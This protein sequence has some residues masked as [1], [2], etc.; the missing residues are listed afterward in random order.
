[1]LMPPGHVR[2]PA[3]LRGKT[4]T[5]ERDLGAFPN[6]EALAYAQPAPSL[7]LHRVR[8]AMGEIWGGEAENP[9]DTLDAEIYEHWLEAVD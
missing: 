4:G 1:M 2:T 9:T 8:F 7:A 6:P 5:I 3:Y